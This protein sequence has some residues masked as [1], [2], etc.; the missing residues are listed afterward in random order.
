MC[1]P[2]LR[3]RFGAMTSMHMDETTP[4]AA[5]PPRVLRRS[6]DDRM[7]AGV[8]G[9]LGAYFG[10]DPVL[11]RVLFATSAFFGGAGI[12]AYLLAWAAIPEAGTEHAPID[13]WI[14]TLRRRQIPTWVVA[15]AAGVLLWIVSFSWWAPGP[16]IPVVGVAIVLA[17]VLSR[18]ARREKPDADAMPPWPPAYDDPYQP[19]VKLSKDDL[20]KDD[21][22]AAPNP[23][24]GPAW[25]DEARV[26]RDEARS[27]RSERIRRAT[28]VRVTTALVLVGTL[29]TLGLIDSVR[30][31]LLPVYFWA[32]LGIVGLGLLVGAA[33]R[34]A[35]WA[36]AWLLIPA[37]IGAVAFSGT[38][39]SLH[40]GVGQRTWTPAAAAGTYKLAFGKGTLDLREL[41][42]AT[43]GSTGTSAVRVDMAAGQVRVI[44][45][46]HANIAVDAH[47]RFGAVASGTL[48]SNGDVVDEQ[49]LDRGHGINQTVAPDHATGT[50][51]DV[52]V[53][54]SAGIVEVLH[55]TN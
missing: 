42:P 43:T 20:A 5:A 10:V 47:I 44:V 18:N 14:A 39:A 45:P 12:L 29:V 6:R 37:I 48:R 36:L 7:G 4:P 28:P 11:F 38:R 9:G 49:H 35:P 1:P 31:I 30:G 25:L 15:V 8:A 55:T 3:G 2:P 16:F 34:R 51:V 17:L 26:W 27:A 23:P 52:D 24:S 32:T 13:T 54:L 22:A 19:T 21:L 53:Y 50:P 46:A 41:T 40:D 33:L